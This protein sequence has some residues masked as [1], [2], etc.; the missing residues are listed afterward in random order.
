MKRVSLLIVLLL[1]AIGLFAKTTV[2]YHTSDTHGYYYPKNGVG[3]FAALASV[4]KKGP[5]PY[6][7]LDSGDFANGTAEAK[8]S[9]GIKSVQLMNKLGYQ[10]TTIGNHEF[11]FKEAAIA[12]MFDALDF[13]VL[14]ANF[15]DAQTN[16]YPAHVKPYEIFDVDGVKVAV[17]GLANRAAASNTKKYKF[18]KPMKALKKALKEVEALHPNIV[19]VIVHDSLHD[20]KHG[21]QPYV[22]DIG[23]KFS[24]R[25][26]LVLGGHAHIFVNEKIKDTLYVE[27]G[28]NLQ[29]VNKITL[30]TDDETGKFVSAQAELIPLEIA[31]VGQDAKVAAY[32]KSLMEPGMDKVIGKAAETISISSNDPQHKD[33]PLNNFIA[34]LGR[35][36]TG[37]QIFAQN[38]GGT[39]VDLPK[40]TITRHDVVD[41]NPFDN[42]IIVM[43]VDGKFLKYLVKHTLLP[44]S[45]YTYS[46]M[47]ITYRNKNG[48]VKDLQLF[49]DGQPVENHKTYTF[50]TNDY[51][52]AGNMEGWPFKRIKAEDKKPF[53]TKGLRTLLE[54]GIAT[55]SPLIA[56]PTGR[57]VEVK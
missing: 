29:N 34:D 45:L 42:K 50:A 47:T 19:V 17:I 13:P 41:V 33:S 56:L 40:G 57:I 11:D 32:A 51:V 49:V 5:H 55:Q 30:V 52:A 38:N 3:G 22:G 23:R 31:K 7:L 27:S 25:V 21:V 18:L 35:A 8:S 39:R 44:R 16:T 28:C 46:G 26:N 2:I 6:L 15:V 53:G 4:L 12:P 1:T 14:A 43:T 37:V 24:D 10:A 20:Q 36:Y 54:E 48:K 9:K